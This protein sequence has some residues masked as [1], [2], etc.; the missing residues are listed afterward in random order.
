MTLHPHLALEPFKR[1][2]AA[3][4]T[5]APRAPSIVDGFCLLPSLEFAVGSVE[6]DDCL[7]AHEAARASP[8]A[9][10]EDGQN[11]STRATTPAGPTGAE[12]AEPSPR[13]DEPMK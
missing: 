3:R 12:T 8:E 5:R 7:L 10:R 2:Q 4:G 11:D 1:K 9:L 6:P 13:F